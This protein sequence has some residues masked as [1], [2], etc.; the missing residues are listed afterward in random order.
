MAD[1]DWVQV[2]IDAGVRYHVVVPDSSL[3]DLYVSN[4]KERFAKRLGG[5]SET[6]CDRVSRHWNKTIKSLSDDKDHV[7]SL[8][9]LD[10]GQ[11]LEDVINKLI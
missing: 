6:F 1:P 5:G 10:E 8:T 4:Y 3:K 11:W 7:I 2:F 9:V